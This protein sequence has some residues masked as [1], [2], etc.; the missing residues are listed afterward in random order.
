MPQVITTVPFPQ[1]N[2]YLKGEAGE[3]RKLEGSATGWKG[4]GCES[5]KRKDKPGQT[6][7]LDDQG[8]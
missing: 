7:L 1:I 3:E 8:G 6:G 2:C 5:P 4:E